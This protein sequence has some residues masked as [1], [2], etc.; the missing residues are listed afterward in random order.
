MHPFLDQDQ[1]LVDLSESLLYVYENTL[2]YYILIQILLVTQLFTGIFGHKPTA[3]IVSLSGH[4]PYSSDKNFLDYLVVGPMCRYAKDLYPLLQIMSGD[5]AKKLKLDEPILTKN[6]KIYYRENAGES[7]SF[8]PVDAEIQH[9]MKRAL[10][11]FK[12][13]GLVVERA[14]SIDLTDS[15]E[16][17]LSLLMGIKEIPDLLGYQKDN[18]LRDHALTEMAKCFIGRSQYTFSS[19]VV[20]HMNESRG[21]IPENKIA[22]Y[23]EESKELRKKFIVRIFW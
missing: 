12:S 11:H 18:K 3:G 13:N 14:N 1:I 7:L 9:S 5:N 6:I 10:E 20:A 16:M 8:I 2:F 4:F 17:G 23:T 19:L 22:K 15:F 21:M